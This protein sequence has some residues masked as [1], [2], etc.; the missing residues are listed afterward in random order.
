MEGKKVR[1]PR[2][3]PKHSHECPPP[4]DQCTIGTKKK[5]PKDDIC[6]E[7]EKTCRDVMNEEAEKAKQ[8]LSSSEHATESRGGKKKND[9]CN[10][11]A[12]KCTEPASKKEEDPCAV[13][14]KK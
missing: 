5:I 11:T 3:P 13:K 1:D 8:Q 9:P 12:P 14:K 7:K 2:C 4:I 10:P 6:A